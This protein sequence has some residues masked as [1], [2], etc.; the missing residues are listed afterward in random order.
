MERINFKFVYHTLIKA[1]FFT[2]TPP[3]IAVPSATP[4]P[5]EC[6]ACPGWHNDE[7]ITA[8]MCQCL[9]GKFWNGETCVNRTECPCYVGYIA[10]SVGTLYDSHDC[11]ECICKIGGIASCKEKIC[12]H[13][14]QV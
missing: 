10:Y 2:A 9:Q 6:N 1:Q 13:C 8:G 5:P 12:P 7:T 14:E 4:A 11:K 3:A